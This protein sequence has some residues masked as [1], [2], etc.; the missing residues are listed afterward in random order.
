MKLLRVRV[1][2]A[3]GLPRGLDVHRFGNEITLVVGPNASGKT[4]VARVVQAVVWP[5]LARRDDLVA[6]V[7]WSIDGVVWSAEREGVR[8]TWRR[9]ASPAAEPPG[10]PPREL[11][12]STLVESQDLAPP[13]PG[14]DD[15]RLA[16]RISM[17][18][19]GGF[20]VAGALRELG[21]RHGGQVGARSGARRALREARRTVRDLQREQSQLADEEARLGE[22]R[23]RLEAHRELGGREES[24]RRAIE[25]REHRAREADLVA[26]LRTLPAAAG[27]VV[28]DEL[29]ALAGL[30][31]AVR[32]AET[33]IEAARAALDE[34][35]RCIDGHWMRQP[36]RDEL[37]TLLEQRAADLRELAR[38]VDEA[39]DRAA[40]ARAALVRARARLGD[41]FAAG[42]DEGGSLTDDVLER[43]EAWLRASAELAGRRAGLDEERHLLESGSAP[44]ASAD[45]LRDA[46]RVLRDL[47]G[48][49]PSRGARLVV[50]AS[51]LAAFAASVAA[52]ALDERAAWGALVAAALA[53]LVASLSSWERRSKLRDARARLR[54]RGLSPP[55]AWTREAIEKQVAEL[56]RQVVEAERAEDAKRRLA[57]LVARLDALAEE[58][59]RLDAQAR[60]L[61]ETTGVD[62]LA[63]GVRSA[64]LA[65]HLANLADARAASE[66]ADGRLDVL[67]TRFANDERAL[68]DALASAEASAPA[69]PE[70]DDESAWQR[71]RALGRRV[72]RLAQDDDT[73]RRWSTEREDARRELE[74]VER[75]RT[76][77]VA[78][79]RRLFERAGLE[80]GDRD[81]LSDAVRAHGRH[82]ELQESLL[83]VRGAIASE[84]AYL[85]E[86]VSLAELEDVE[87]TRR[88]EEAVSARDA[89]NELAETITRIETQVDRARGR[90]ALEHAL[91]EE[92]AQRAAFEA[93]REAALSAC[94]QGWLLRRA[95]D[96]HVARDQPAVLR[97]AKRLFAVF[98]KDRFEL[99]IEAGAGETPRFHAIDVSNGRRVSIAELSTGTRTQLLLAARLAFLE[100]SEGERRL[101]VFLDEVLGYSDPERFR[102]VVESL[103]AV[104]R[105]GRQIVYL[106]CQPSDVAAWRSILGASDS[107][108]E[109]VELGRVE[110]AFEA[111]A[112]LLPRPVPSADGL[113]PD[114]YARRVGVPAFDPHA[115]VGSMHLFH[116]L[117]DRLDLLERLL[118]SGIETLGQWGSVAAR[119]AGARYAGERDARRLDARTVVA[120]DVVRAW[121]IGRPPPVP[122]ALLAEAGVSETFEEEVAALL[123]ELDGDGSALVAALGEGRVKG[124]RKAKIDELRDA[125]RA[126]GHL[127]DRQP[128]SVEAIVGRAIAAGAEHV[129]SGALDVD[130]PA[131]VARGILAG[132]VRVTPADA[133]AR[134][135]SRG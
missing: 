81:G 99:G 88:R 53:S 35:T 107:G 111:D 71:A 106:T 7:E 130:E 19:A 78:E 63:S 112:S 75:E 93:E 24:Y 2:R 11:A 135:S 6:R 5:D 69:T 72:E 40:T 121:S 45:D 17:A 4:T 38:E 51:S 14:E 115:G 1:E 30:D 49:S 32:G 119:G 3:A 131:R 8:V 58:G 57:A 133:A 87:L 95:H 91:A 68:V 98:T 123:A 125:L 85:G 77:T 94:A 16:R 31:D 76:R 128:P 120:E 132:T 124:Y 89:A 18:L 25:L 67:E 65:R 46:A 102:A 48:A 90:R 60:E 62:V 104:A 70:D 27:R 12:A 73:L 80:D 21:T 22:L 83:R 118:R 28:G 39:S 129:A 84:E 97:E 101:P 33:R 82:V 52:L 109:I 105:E 100:A 64:E 66:E 96:E 113:T 37:R 103:R 134:G 44:R 50:L 47:L 43:I 61:A 74:S 86:D 15:A 10:L 20:D 126:R 29:G 42:P 59:Q 127:D 114:E 117:R 116:L 56:D 79:R 36:L 92:D 110:Q 55:D 41:A 13:R 54:S 23:E 34:A 122:R 26:Q 108:L 9:E